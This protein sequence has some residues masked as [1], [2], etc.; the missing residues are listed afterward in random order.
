MYTLIQ[1]SIDGKHKASYQ[2]DL[3]AYKAFHN[4]RAV[5]SAASV[6]FDLCVISPDGRMIEHADSD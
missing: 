3:D 4:C 6:P 1:A 5:F 2:T